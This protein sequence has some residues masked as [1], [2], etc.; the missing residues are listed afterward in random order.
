[1]FRI[2]LGQ[3]AHPFSK[4]KGKKLVLGG[5]RLPRFTG[6][7]ANSDGDVIFHS[8]CNAMSSAIGGDSLGTWA[9][10]FC[11]KKGVGDSAVYLE[12]IFGRTKSEGYVVGNV[13][14]SLEGSLPR[15]KLEALHE[16]KE[17][18]ARRLGIGLGQVGLTITS[19]NGLGTFAR[20]EGMQAF[21]IVLLEKDD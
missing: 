21:S 2:G 17:S 7:Q 5:V 3:D 6:F 12:Y 8:L 14:V 10:E 19:G 20:G 4:D 11:L 13:S 18:V 1:M 16:I 9:D 15:L